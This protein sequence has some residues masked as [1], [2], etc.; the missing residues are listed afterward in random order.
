MMLDDINLLRRR[1]VRV[2]VAASW[3]NTVAVT[4]ISLI[5]GTDRLLPLALIGILANLLPTVMV[6]QGRADAQARLV[7]ASLAAVQPALIVYALSGH[8]WQMDGHM[9]FFVA[10]AGLTVLCDVRAILFASALIAVH[11]LV[12]QYAAPAWVF[13]GAGDLGRVLFHALAVV[14][15]AAVL[16]YLTVTIRTLL[17]HNAEA[18][19]QSEQAATTAE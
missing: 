1:G 7:V 5:A 18:R 16:V 11:H 2:L 19:A 10:L 4:L 13:S 6:R 12:L 9:Y 14:L 15:Q 8:G 3:A 17:N